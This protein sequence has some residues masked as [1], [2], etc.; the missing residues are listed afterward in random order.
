MIVG[1]VLLVLVAGVLLGLGLVR[2][3]EPLL[4]SSIGVSALAALTLVIGV[5]RLAA[6]R[7]GRGTIA[8]R[9]VV[10]QGQGA[11]RPVGRATPRPVGRAAVSPLS[12]AASAAGTSTHSVDGVAPADPDALLEDDPT[13][14]ADEPAAESVSPDELTRFAQL[15]AEVLVVDGRPRFHLADC[16]HLLGMDAEPVTTAEAVEY[17]FTPCDLCRPVTALGLLADVDD[18]AEPSTA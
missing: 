9:R 7:A 8:V 18:D 5:R 2:L 1:S 11:P 3:D 4:Y 14:P 10:A 15:P 17:G 13:V 12:P 6:V 16:L